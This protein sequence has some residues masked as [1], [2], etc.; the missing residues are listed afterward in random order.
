MFDNIQKKS[1]IEFSVYHKSLFSN[2]ELIGNAIFIFQDLYS[3]NL[4]KFITLYD[5]GTAVGSL[6]INLNLVKN[7]NDLKETSNGKSNEDNDI[8]EELMTSIDYRD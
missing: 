1:Q 8:D 7:K 3:Y 4:K 2:E 6:H 5:K